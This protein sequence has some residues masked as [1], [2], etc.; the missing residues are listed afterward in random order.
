MAPWGARTSP[1]AEGKLPV[2][3]AGIVEFLQ[4]DCSITVDLVASDGSPW[5]DRGWALDVV[6]P[7]NDVAKVLLSAGLVS[8]TGLH[9][10]TTLAVTATDDAYRSVRMRGPVLAACSATRSDVARA[11]FCDGGLRAGWS[12]HGGGRQDP[13]RLVP[14]AY[15]TVTFFAAVTFALADSRVLAGRLEPTGRVDGAPLPRAAVSV[16]GIDL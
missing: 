3:D 8:G 15:V 1:G 14:A 6:S 13:R 7:T 12:P 11:R 2:L 5:V 16:V 4:S 9:P 10:D